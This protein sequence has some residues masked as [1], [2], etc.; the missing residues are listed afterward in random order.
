M[1][2]MAIDPGNEWS[3]WVVYETA[4]KCPLK[5]CKSPNSDLLNRIEY[6][7]EDIEWCAIEQVASYGMAVGKEVFETVYWSGIFAHAFGLERVVRIP[8]KDVKIHLCGSLKAKDSNIRQAI[9]DRYGGK[10]KAIGTK[11]TGY[12]PLHGINSD[13]WAALSVAIT[14][15]ETKL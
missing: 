7:E 6:T 8:R 14:A 4:D 5:W 15:A 1:L 10:D 3:G 13:V 2:I 11:K 9:V 12:G